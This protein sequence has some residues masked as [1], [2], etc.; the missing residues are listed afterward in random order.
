MSAITWV[1]SLLFQNLQQ[2]IGILE[3]KRTKIPK[4]HISKKFNVRNKG[5][6]GIKANKNHSEGYFWYTCDLWLEEFYFVF[7]LRTWG[8]LNL[9]SFH[10]NILYAFK[11]NSQKRNNFPFILYQNN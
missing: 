1:A 7:W 10:H 2:T 9:E 8:L 5:G 4:A 6:K 11:W 3:K